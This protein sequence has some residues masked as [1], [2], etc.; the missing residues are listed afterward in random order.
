MTMQGW[1]RDPFDSA[2]TAN[3]RYPTQKTIAGNLARNGALV[4]LQHKP[5]TSHQAEVFRVRQRGF[6]VE[7]IQRIFQRPQPA[8]TV[9]GIPI[10]YCNRDRECSSRGQDQKMVS[11]KH[12]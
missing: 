1:E 5:M 2:I 10:Y 3:G 11:R 6:H 7:L 9:P 8:V 4:E 12:R